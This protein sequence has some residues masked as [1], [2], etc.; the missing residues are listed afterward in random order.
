MAK[1]A[2]PVFPGHGVL[3]AREGLASSILSWKIDLVSDTELAKEIEK[4]SAI[5][6]LSPTAPE[7]G[8]A[9]YTAMAAEILTRKEMLPKLDKKDV[10]KATEQILKDSKALASYMTTSLKVHKKN[11]PGNV[12]AAMDRMAKELA[13]DIEVGHFLVILS[14]FLHR[15]HFF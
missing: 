7:T 14:G 1:P 6:Q 5:L 9:L 2:K 3:L 12:N 8:V 13:K 4:L 11:V 15:Q 10:G